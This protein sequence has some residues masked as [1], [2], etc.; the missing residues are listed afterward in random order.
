M[1][2]YSSVDGNLKG[3]DSEN[4]LQALDYLIGNINQQ[5]SYQMEH[6]HY[7]LKDQDVIVLGGG[8]TAMDCVRSAIRQQAKS[9]R[10][11]YRKDEQAMPGSRT[12]VQNAK[13]EG[14]QFLFNLQPLEINGDGILCERTDFNEL[15]HKDKQVTLKADTIILAF[16]FRA[17]PANWLADVQIET[18]DSGLIKTT[19]ELQTSN[20]K[21]YAGGD[22]VSGADLVVTAIAQGRDAAKQ[23]LAEFGVVDD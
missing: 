14:V 17:S 1:G 16:G 2:T 11:V 8:D 20:A 12:E 13:E 4:T 3:T 7:D 15:K 6:E 5:Q 18:E 23:I 19:Q 9:V 22:M 10:C 21:I